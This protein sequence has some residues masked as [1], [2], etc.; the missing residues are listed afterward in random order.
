MLF[1][2]FLSP[3]M[4][5]PKMQGYL[6][7]SHVMKV[8]SRTLK[9]AVFHL[10]SLKKQKISNDNHLW[11]NAMFDFLLIKQKTHYLKQKMHESGAV[12]P[13]NSSL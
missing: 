5:F 11:E 8:M 12:F 7:A 10:F 13:G 2:H 3:G 1:M 9:K 4:S 6:H